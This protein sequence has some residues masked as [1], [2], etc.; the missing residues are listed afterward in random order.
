M[1]RFSCPV[2]AN[3]L[4]FDSCTC[5]NCKTDV[6]YQP[7]DAVFLALPEQGGAQ[8]IRACANRA[9]IDCN[10]M[11][12]P[13]AGEYCLACA[14]N[15][16]IPDISVAK[17]VRL[18]REI[19]LAKRYLFYSILRWRL[20]HPLRDEDTPDGLAFDFLADVVRPDGSVKRVLTGH[21]NGLITLNI[22]EGDDAERVSRREALGE[23][24][25]TLIGHM[26]HEVGHY[27]WDRL[28]RDGDRVDAF[29]D[30]FGDER[31]SY[32]DALKAHYANGPQEGWA[33][34]FISS[35]AASHPWED[36]AE[37]W[38]HY[39]HI[40]DASETA[41]AFGMS[42]Q[43]SRFS[44]E[45]VEVE[46]N[47]YHSRDFDELIADWVPLTVAVNCLNRSIGQPDMYPFVLSAP[48][49]RKLGFIH[50]IVGNAT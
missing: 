48:V 33:D 13:G 18:W 47:P 50:E 31:A 7:I 4:H 25:R 10:W 15:R 39:I 34:Q 28:I 23:P 40:V 36:W 24:Y 41:H 35:Y 1:K 26:R 14:H 46:G 17:N 42:I 29:R 3:E 37:T 6:V 16:T 32:G 20:P 45:E 49:K 9:L 5:V 11:V 2:C 30:I 21:A 22:A 43:A 19:D 12:R 38:A 8:A 44:G 27:Y